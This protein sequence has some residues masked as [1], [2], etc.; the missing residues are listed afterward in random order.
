MLYNVKRLYYSDGVVDTRIY[1][2]SISYGEEEKK[3]YNCYDENRQRNFYDEERR[4]QN[5]K[6]SESRTKQSIYE[7][8]RD[9]KWDYFITMTFAKEK[10]D[11]YDYK[12][13]SK[14]LSIW[15]NNARK[16][17]KDL[18]Y[19]IVP[20]LHK[21]GAYHF[22]GLVSGINEEDLQDSG[23]KVDGEIIYNLRSYKLGFTTLTKVRCND[24]VVRYILKYITK[25]LMKRTSGMKRYWVSR[26]CDRP[27]VEVDFMSPEDQCFMWQELSEDA[28]YKSQV[29]T[30][31]NEVLY[32]QNRR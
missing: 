19:V 13:V 26:N 4:L 5:K 29:K 18:K 23:H 22:H 30:G 12:E 15:L 11:R 25:D 9:N 17:Y 8:A 7:I 21:D 31:I 1:E 20:E 28:I 32:L 16:K 14:K 27:S 2:H 24:A 10:V 3:F 6:R